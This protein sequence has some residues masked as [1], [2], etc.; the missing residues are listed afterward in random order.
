MKARTRA[1]KIRAK[2]GRPRKE[3]VE[4]TPSGQISRATDFETKIAA[5]AATWKRRQ[6]NPELSIDEARKPEHGSVIARWLAEWQRMKKLY[7]E[8]NH[9]NQFTQL[10]Y[11]TAM[12]Y[13][14]LYMDW[15]A[16]I[17]A[18]NPRSASDFTGQGG[19]DGSDPFE[20]RRA[21]RN[22]AIERA[23][24]DA[25][26]AVLESGPFGMMAIETIVIEN[27]PADN[28]RADLRLALNRLAILFRLQD[29]A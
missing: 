26:R 18:R 11:D 4:R 3:G 20:D 22:R 15:M 7:P 10:H 9:P 16:C 5:E 21:K 17:D 23:F 8:A 12:R 29:A 27:Q 19:F 1:A 28:L 6:Q 24:K 13:H 2:R 14:Q 25:R